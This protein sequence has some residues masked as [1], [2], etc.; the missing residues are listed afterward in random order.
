MDIDSVQIPT[1]PFTYVSGTATGVGAVPGSVRVRFNPTG[2]TPGAYTASATITVSD[3]NIPGA[4][5]AQVVAT[6]SATIGGGNPSDLNGDGIVNGAD[7]GILLAA[8][9]STGPADLDQD[10]SV[11]GSDLAVLLGNWG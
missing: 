5:T 4:R 8:W 10:G 9:G 2:L 1:G 3:E 6:L 7:L 11:G